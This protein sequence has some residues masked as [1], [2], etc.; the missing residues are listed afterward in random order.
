MVTLYFSYLIYVSP[1]TYP[2][3]QLLPFIIYH[4]SNELNLLSYTWIPEM[5]GNYLVVF[6][7]SGF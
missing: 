3:F 2:F 4:I 6:C 5:L 1:T 7:R